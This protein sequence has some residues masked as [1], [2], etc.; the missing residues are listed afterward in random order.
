VQ[1]VGIEDGDDGQTDAV[2]D[3]REQDRKRTTGW[4]A[5]KARRAISQTSDVGGSRDATA[6]GDVGVAGDAT[7]EEASDGAEHA[8]GKRPAAG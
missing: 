2:V 8:A 7:G 3:H 1:R 6:A 4:S 5:P